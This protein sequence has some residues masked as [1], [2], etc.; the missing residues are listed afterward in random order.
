MTGGSG[1]GSDAS[2]IYEAETSS[3][4]CFLPD[5]FVWFF[6]DATLPPVPFYHFGTLR[7]PP[8]NYTDGI[9]YYVL[10]TFLVIVT[11]A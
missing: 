10:I 8:E 9:T 11:N 1:A 4:D 2:R 7:I 5:K 6:G 3:R